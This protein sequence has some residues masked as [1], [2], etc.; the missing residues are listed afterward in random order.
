MGARW[1]Y[2]AMRRSHRGSGSGGGVEM[3]RMEN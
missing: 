3:E 2:V 1:Q